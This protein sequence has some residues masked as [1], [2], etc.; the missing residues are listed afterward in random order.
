ML[1]LPKGIHA[2]MRADH[3]QPH[4]HRR[5]SILLSNLRQTLRQFKLLEERPHA[6]AQHHHVRLSLLQQAIPAVGGSAA[7]HQFQARER[8]RAINSLR[9]FVVFCLEPLDSSIADLRRAQ[10]TFRFGYRPIVSQTANPISSSSSI[11]IPKLATRLVDVSQ[12]NENVVA[13]FRFY[14]SSE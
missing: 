4:P 9:H 5:Q 14:L 3:S 2:E 1:A 12:L 10:I 7:P 13:V 11:K 6:E 8:Q